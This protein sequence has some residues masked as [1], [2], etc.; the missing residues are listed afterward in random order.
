MQA[1]RALTIS[2][3]SLS[4][5]WFLLVPGCNDVDEGLYGDTSFR[6]TEECFDNVCEPE[7]EDVSCDVCEDSNPPSDGGCWITGIGYVNDPD[8]RDNFGGNGM[9][10]KAGYLRGEWEHVDH[11]TGVKYH[12]K[13][14]YLFCQ[15]VDEAGPEQPS[16]PDHDLSMNQAYYGGPGKRYTPG[17]GW[18]EGF[19]FDV[20]AEDHG[21]PGKSDE[22][23]F[24]V[25]PY[26][27]TV[28][29]AGAT[30]YS[31]GGVL[32][33]GNFQIHPPN[34]GHPFIEG[35][36]PSWVTLQP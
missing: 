1:R 31:T 29:Q 28:L 9:P 19:W 2:T 7:C 27:M 13:I 26:D 12:G 25:R 32:G 30:E 35:E 5:A 6:I 21:E 34:A 17:V 22:Y 16:G 14:A 11:G 8:G 24:S 4:L 33:G 18:E 3:V 15:H 23:Y 20:M 36:L 10:M